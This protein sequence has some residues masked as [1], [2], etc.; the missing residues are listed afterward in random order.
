MIFHLDLR[1]T[2][3]LFI[4]LIRGDFAIIFYQIGLGVYLIFAPVSLA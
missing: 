3:F 2:P 4:G 1:E